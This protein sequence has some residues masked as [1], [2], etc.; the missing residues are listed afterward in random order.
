M[1][2][3]FTTIII[4]F[5]VFIN[6]FGAYILRYS[7]LDPNNI[8]SNFFNHGFFDQGR[9]SWV[10]GFEW[11]KGSGKNAIFTTGINL[12][13][14]ING[15]LRQ[16][17]SSYDGE[18]VEGICNSGSVITNPNFKIYKVSRGDKYTT[19][20]Y[21]ANW[22]LMVPYGAPYTDVNRNGKY[23]PEIDIPGVQ[24]AAST[25]FMCFTDADSSTRYGNEGGFGGGTNPLYAEI[26]LTAWA[27]SDWSFE[28]MQFIKYE[29]INKGNFPWNNTF[30]TIFSDPDIGE[31]W[32]DYIGCDTVRKLGYS[33]NATNFDS[34]YGANP[35]AVGFVF[36]KG[37]T[38]KTL[39]ANP[40]L[41]MTSFCNLLSPVFPGV[42]CEDGSGYAYLY[43]KGF[44]G[45]S[46]SWLDV[47]HPLGGNHYKRTKFC[48]YGDPES[49]SGWTEF[50]GSI[51]NCDHGMNDTGTVVAPN[52]PGDRRI[53]MSSG[54]ENLTVNP[55][56]TQTVYLC[57]LIA[58]GT[59][60]LNSVSK[61]KK[62]S[63]RAQYFYNMNFGIT[64]NTIISKSLPEAYSL[65]QN[66]PNPFNP[67]TTIKFTIP[68]NQTETSRNVE[69]AVTDITGKTV[70]TL[71]NRIL[72]AGEYEIIFDG[73]GLS[74]GIYFCTLNAHN[75]QI[76]R[77]MLMIK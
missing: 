39:I 46:S 55:G 65:S 19:N 70:A 42:N 8:R 66:Y 34:I 61:L 73:T 48:Y 13:A 74:S 41:G 27:Y 4:L 44:K 67:K 60:N 7:I 32:D 38:D 33:Y 50:N 17:V 18:F 14:R 63:D 11:P 29:I 36:L 58:Q 26:H 77:K 12:T 35:P 2:S 47:S 15:E 72:P 5:F 51:H 20:P 31:T 22:G 43:M 37:L 24:D 16:A 21:W 3:K 54:S 75:V 64:I 25:I 49:N 1:K 6:C 71:V 53:I 62:L 30:F 40:E 57:Q 56:D 9:A 10:P 59:S 45:D 52:I 76:T 28:D 23:E 68:P 69:L